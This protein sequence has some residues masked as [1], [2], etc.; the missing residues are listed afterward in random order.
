VQCWNESVDVFFEFMPR[1]GGPK[2]MPRAPSKIKEGENEEK[3]GDDEKDEDEVVG[4]RGQSFR[5]DRRLVRLLIARYWTD[6]IIRKFDKFTKETEGGGEEG[7]E[8][9]S[10]DK[11]MA[12]LTLA[13]LDKMNEERD[14]KKE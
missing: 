5:A 11:P 8:G 7:K 13:G 2:L 12:K 9:D 1:L 10:V 6:K 3:E 4:A 14:A